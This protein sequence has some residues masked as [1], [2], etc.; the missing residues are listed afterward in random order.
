MRDGLGKCKVPQIFLAVLVEHFSA[1]STC[2]L[3]NYVAEVR[4]GKKERKKKETGNILR[5]E[6]I[7]ISNDRSFHFAFSTSCFAR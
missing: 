5:I 1:I 4:L 2:F 3:E 7:S 6:S